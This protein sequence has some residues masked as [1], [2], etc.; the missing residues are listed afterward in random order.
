MITIRTFTEITADRQVIISLPAET[1]IGK[2]ELVITVSP[3]R[4]TPLPC[5]SLRQ[6]FGTVHSGEAR[7]ADNERIDGDLTRAYGNLQS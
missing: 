4:P 5:G 7:S 1:P 2:A 3:P 6:R